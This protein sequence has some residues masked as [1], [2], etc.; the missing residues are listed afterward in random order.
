[1]AICIKIGRL[2]RSQVKYLIKLLHH[3]RV[4][5][6]EI[7]KKYFAISFFFVS[8]QS[9]T[10][11]TYSLCHHINSKIQIYIYLHICFK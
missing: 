11:E 9:G 5:I 2:T 8:S 7:P 6:M 1:M 3:V 10:E 4:L